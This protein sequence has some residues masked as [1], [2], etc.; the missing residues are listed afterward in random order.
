MIDSGL[1]FEF[2]KSIDWVRW[3]LTHHFMP[4]LESPLVCQPFF[5]WTSS[6]LFWLHFCSHFREP[7]VIRHNVRLSTISLPYSHLVI[8]L[9]HLK[10]KAALTQRFNSARTRLIFP[11]IYW[12]LG[13]WKLGHA[14]QLTEFDLQICWICFFAFDRPQDSPQSCVWTRK[15]HFLGTQRGLKPMIWSRVQS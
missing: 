7:L 1:S 3:S 6:G 14:L 2:S 12:A 5:F 11:I 15:I 8:L 10:K 13:G 4:P 9:S